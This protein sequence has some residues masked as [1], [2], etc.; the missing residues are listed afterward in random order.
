MTPA[1]VVDLPA[2]QYFNLM[3]TASPWLGRPS[4]TASTSCGLNHS[5]PG[6]DALL[7]LYYQ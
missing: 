7:Y 1:S 5:L 3:G 2:Q 4:R 6:Y